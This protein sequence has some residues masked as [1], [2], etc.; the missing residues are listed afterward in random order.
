MRTFNGRVGR[1]NFKGLF[2]KNDNFGHD[3]SRKKERSM[4]VVHTY[5]HGQMVDGLNTLAMLRSGV[6]MKT[7]SNLYHRETK[8]HPP[9]LQIPN[10][11]KKNGK[12]T[13]HQ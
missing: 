5:T 7:K 4:F 13:V 1:G 9:L 11:K 2:I 6:Q 3:G 12:T 8:T 10:I